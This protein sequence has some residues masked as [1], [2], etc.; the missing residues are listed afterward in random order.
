MKVVVIN[1]SPHMDKGNT[2][3]I[4]KPFLEGVREAGTEVKIYYTKKLKINSCQ[5]EYHCWYKTPGK[6]FQ[7][8]DMQKV[9]P[10]VSRANILI[11][12]TPVYVDGVTGP[13]KNF[14]DR[15]IPIGHPAIELREGH[16]RH[17]RREKVQDGK[18]VLVSNC[19]FW[20]LDNFDP[21]IMHMQAI[22][23]NLGYEFAGALLRP[24]G[25]ALRGM[26]EQGV[27]VDDIF[28]AAKK[29]G[30]QLVQNGKMSKD[31]LKVI[32]RELL[33]Q[34]MYVDIANQR[35]HEALAKLGIEE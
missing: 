17:P 31:T 4:L 28:E 1:G 10:E 21:M 7:D 19:G 22:S 3:L 33:A 27:A 32:S 18:L 13:L 34:Q 16:C 20:E 23:K 14:L 25:A 35:I 12:A 29:A 30:R 9:L 26:M 15:L 5:G 6:C 24:H 11:F 8:D 2:A